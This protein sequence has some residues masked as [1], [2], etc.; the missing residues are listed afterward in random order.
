LTDYKL[1]AGLLNQKF[2]L[3][4]L[5]TIQFEFQV[6]SLINFKRFLSLW[7]HILLILNPIFQNQR[8]AT[9]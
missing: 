9:G 3:Y 1:T 8:L 6:F 5:G 4:R 2:Q 7:F